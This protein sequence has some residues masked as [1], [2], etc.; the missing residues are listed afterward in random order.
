MSSCPS[1]EGSIY[2]TD[3]QGYVNFYERLNDF[4]SPLGDLGIFDNGYDEEMLN[5]RAMFRRKYNKNRHQWR[6][7]PKDIQKIVEVVF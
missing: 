6:L 7:T 1:I 5:N 2:R 4:R 3:D